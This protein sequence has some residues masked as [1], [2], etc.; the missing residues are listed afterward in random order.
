MSLN[1]GSAESMKMRGG[2][3]DYKLYLPGSCQHQSL[4]HQGPPSLQ[5]GRRQILHHFQDQQLSPPIAYELAYENPQFPFL[6]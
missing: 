1:R 6:I 5:Q 2:I 3:R 4:S